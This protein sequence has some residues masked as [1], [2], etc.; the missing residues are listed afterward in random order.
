MEIFDICIC[1]IH[2][3]IF[4]SA[5]WLIRMRNMTHSYVRHDSFVCETWLIRMWD[6]THSCLLHHRCVAGLSSCALCVHITH[7]HVQHGAFICAVWLICM[8]DMTDSY[9]L[10]HRCVA[11]LSSCARCVD[12]THSHVPHSYVRHDSFVCET[13]HIHTCHIWPQVARHGTHINESCHTNEW[14]MSH[15]WMSES[16]AYPDRQHPR[17]HCCRI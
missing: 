7:S 17:S 16:R 3:S 4:A 11:G 1:V 8:W 2:T 9:L 13:W 14:V 5:A 15:I 6:M 10:H 12:M